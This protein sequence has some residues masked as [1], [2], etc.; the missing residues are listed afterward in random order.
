MLTL[1]IYHVT[2]V[3]FRINSW[4]FKNWNDQNGIQTRNLL[5]LKRTLGYLAIYSNYCS[6]DEN[7]LNAY[8]GR[9]QGFPIPATLYCYKNEFSGVKV[10][11]LL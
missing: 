5:V 1:C 7:F 11:F 3:F 9:R 2:Y 4:I 8:F 6:T 10:T